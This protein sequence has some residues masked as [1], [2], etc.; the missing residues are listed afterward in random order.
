MWLKPFVLYYL[1]ESLVKLGKIHLIIK[2]V[3]TFAAFSS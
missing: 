2:H 3:F 1:M